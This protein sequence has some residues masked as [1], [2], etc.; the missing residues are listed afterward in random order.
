MYFYTFNN[1][2]YKIIKLYINLTYESN[3]KGIFKTLVFF[4]SI[5]KTVFSM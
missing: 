5:I 4:I 2:K 1:D 3:E